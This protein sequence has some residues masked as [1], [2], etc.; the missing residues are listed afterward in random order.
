MAVEELSRVAE[1][2]RWGD[3]GDLLHQLADRQFRTAWTLES[4]GLS[5]EPA[6]AELRRRRR[7]QARAPQEKSLAQ[8]YPDFSDG[9]ILLGGFDPFGD[10]LTSLAEGD[11]KQGVNELLFA[12]IAVDSLDEM[13]VQFDIFGAQ[14]RPEAQSGKPAPRSSIAMLKPICR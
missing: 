7:H 11:F 4:L 10:G 6:R 13:P 8:R 3:D 2:G 12:V 9:L 1:E 14:L 5:H